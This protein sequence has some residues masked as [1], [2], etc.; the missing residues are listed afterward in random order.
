[1]P[2]KRSTPK[3]QHRAEEL[4]KEPTPAEAKL[5]AHLRRLE[6]DG[7]H[8]RRQQA[9]GRYIVDFCAAR[10]KLVIEVDGSQHIDQQA[11]DARRTAFLESRGYRVLR[12]WNSDVMNKVEE[13]MGVVLDELNRWKAE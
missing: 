13:V 10:R 5:W 9:I 3:M 12:F 7:I 1:M 11:Y 2:P 4:R 6:G 8:F